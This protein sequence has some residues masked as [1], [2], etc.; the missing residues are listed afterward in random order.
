MYFAWAVH[1]NLV[2]VMIPTS[3]YYSVQNVLCENADAFSE[4]AARDNIKRFTAPRH[5]AGKFIEDGS[6]VTVTDPRFMVPL[7]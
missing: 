1:S 4:D 3:H 6:L 5:D 2:G 7:V